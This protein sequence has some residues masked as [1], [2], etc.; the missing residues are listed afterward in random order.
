MNSPIPDDD[1]LGLV[2]QV[3][4]MDL[5]DDIDDDD[6]DDEE[7]REMDVFLKKEYQPDVD[8]ISFA[9]KWASLSSN[10]RKEV[11]NLLLEARQMDYD[12]EEHQ[13]QNWNRKVRLYT[14]ALDLCDDR[15]YIHMRLAN[16]LEEMERNQSM[17][18]PCGGDVG[19]QAK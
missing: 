10:A 13:A 1:W 6:D 9:R 3:E 16:L 19:G 15:H 11:K 14:Q 4:N 18:Q 8:S 17:C 2:E 12:E 7:I 5:E